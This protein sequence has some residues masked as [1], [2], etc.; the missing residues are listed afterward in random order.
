[1]I[2]RTSAILFGTAVV[3]ALAA[4]AGWWWWS[5][6]GRPEIRPTDPTQV[7]LGEVVYRQRCASC[8]GVNLEGQPDWRIRMPNGRLPA[9]P[10][11]AS[12]HT[13]HHPDQVLFD[14]TKLG[15]GPFAPPDYESDMPAFEGVLTDGEIRAV[16][17]YIMSQWPEEILGR[18]QRI[19]LQAAQ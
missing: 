5:Q 2:V 1:M 7:R 9:P 13:W 18:Q 14:I 3:A 8:H 16:I 11:D 15:L 6:L 10:H 17:A 4:V 12:G 19:D